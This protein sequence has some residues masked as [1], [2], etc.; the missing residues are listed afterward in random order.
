MFPGVWEKLGELIEG[1][2]IIASE[3]V[4]HDLSRKDDELFDWANKR[5][6]MF[7][8]IDEEIQLVVAEILKGHKK[9]I[10]TR[11]NRSGSDP[12][13]IALAKIRGCAVVTGEKPSNSEKRPHIPDV[14]AALGLKWIDIVQLLREE[15]L[16]LRLVS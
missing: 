3:E 2:E 6:H 11:R 16:V 5:S 4:K 12:F 1:G 7:I 13:V 9:L 14:C 10:D 15:G 8:P